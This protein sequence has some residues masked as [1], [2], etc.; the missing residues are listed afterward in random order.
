MKVL[1]I[2]NIDSFVYNIVQ[3][4]GAQGCEPSVFR[5]DSDMGDV[6][7]ENPER[8]I[9]SP[10]PKT[11]EESGI[12]VNVVQDMGKEVPTLG[13]CLGHQTIAYAFGGEVIASDQLM[14]GKTSK[15]N[16]TGGALYEGVPNPFEAT[17]YHSLVVKDS[18]LPDCFE[19][20]ARAKDKHGEIMGIKHKDYPIFGTQFH[21]ESI[22]TTDGK[23]NLKKFLKVEQ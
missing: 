22:L 9:I 14:H 12:S 8:I 20:T 15:I 6:K 23:K 3:Y 16:H 18:T 2:D 5:N 13:V 21:P 17:R 11:P 4:V 10:G 19:V 1:I 7:K